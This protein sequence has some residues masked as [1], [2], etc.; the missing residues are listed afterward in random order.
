MPVEDDDYDHSDELR[1][2]RDEDRERWEHE[3]IERQLDPDY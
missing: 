2:Q 3:Q 1:E